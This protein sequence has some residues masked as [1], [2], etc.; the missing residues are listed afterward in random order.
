MPV[1]LERWAGDGW[2]TFAAGHTDID[3]RLRD[4]VPAEMWGPGGYRLVFDTAAH[5]GPDA[6][7]PEVVVAFRVT[8]PTRHYH[9]PLLLS[10]YGYTTYRGS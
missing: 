9:V 7:F 10:P 6:F 8:D 3:G 2:R 1:R 5:S 4:W